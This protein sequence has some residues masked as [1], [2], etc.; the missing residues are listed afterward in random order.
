ML[1][2]IGTKWQQKGTNLHGG[3]VVDG[4]KRTAML[5][6]ESNNMPTES[7]SVTLL[8]NPGK[9]GQ[10]HVLLCHSTIAK[11]LVVLQKE[12]HKCIGLLHGVEMLRIVERDATK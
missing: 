12:K 11:P 2:K 1:Q 4:H 10:P 8:C 5:S 7:K 6:N 9:L 3:S